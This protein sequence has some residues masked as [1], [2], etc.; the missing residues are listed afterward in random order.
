MTRDEFSLIINLSVFDFIVAG[1]AE[2]VD[3]RDSKS[4]D[5][6][7]MS[8]RV[9]L[10][11]P[12]KHRINW[13]L[14]V[15][16]DCIFCKIIERTIPS[17]IVAENDSVIVIKDIAP[18]APTHFLIIPKKHIKDL[19]DVQESDSQLLADMLLITHQLS[20]KLEGSGSFRLIFNTGR[21]VGQSVFHLHSHFL[22]GKHMHDF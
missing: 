20:Q 4:R 10:P 8:V 18:K 15:N 11:A 16:N 12:S 1:M 14:S 13:R 22:A 3:A 7:I 19:R 21:E 5:V 17:E 2:L 9:R 6:R